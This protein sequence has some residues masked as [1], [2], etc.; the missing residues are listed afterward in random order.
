MKFPHVVL[1][2]AW[3]NNIQRVML[4][5]EVVPCRCC[6]RCRLARPCKW[7]VAKTDALFWTARGW[8]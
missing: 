3:I 5:G 2:P 1:I 4:K 7:K 8:R 6:A